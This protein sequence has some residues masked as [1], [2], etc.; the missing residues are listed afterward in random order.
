MYDPNVAIGGHQPAGYDYLADIYSNWQVLSST[1]EITCFPK[2]TE[3][4]LINGSGFVN[5][6]NLLG[7]F[8]SIGV[9]DTATSITGSLTTLTDILERPN[10]KTK[11]INSNSTPTSIRATFSMPK[12]Y[13]RTR[14]L[15]DEEITGGSL[16]DPNDKVYYHFMFGPPDG[17]TDIPSIQFVVRMKFK[18]RWFNPRELRQS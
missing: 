10:I 13:G 1:I 16:T 18:C 2:M 17:S 3:T 11:F 7:A 14:G 15:D 4:A 5:S 9:R 8:M 12:F 6:A